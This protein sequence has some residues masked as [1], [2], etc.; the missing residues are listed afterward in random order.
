M[1]GHIVHRFCNEP[2][3]NPRFRFELLGGSKTI[4]DRWKFQYWKAERIDPEPTGLRAVRESH[5]D[6]RHPGLPDLLTV[7]SIPVVGEPFRQI[8]V[9]L[10]PDVHQFVP[11]VLCDE[12]EQP[13]PG[14]YWLMNVLQ[15]RDCVIRPEQVKRWEAEGYTFPEVELFWHTHKNARRA[16]TQYLDKS[17]IAGLHLWRP[18]YPQYPLGQSLYLFE[19]F[20][21]DELL[22]R[23]E[24]AKL[25][26]LSARPAIE[27]SVPLPL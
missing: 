26:K 21:S 17:Q 5:P 13:L 18:R 25:R 9:E 15:L 20:V 22:R 8:V 24:G 3:Y 12:A 14:T 19:F 2:R 1:A 10:A 23:V 7:A 6:V 4:Q 16:L 27:I 11:V